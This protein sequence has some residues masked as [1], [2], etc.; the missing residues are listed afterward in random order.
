MQ[1]DPLANQT[2]R[3]PAAVSEHRATYNYTYNC[4]KAGV[5]GQ[6]DAAAHQETQ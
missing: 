1:S 6:G 3:I 5:S 4:L 2:A